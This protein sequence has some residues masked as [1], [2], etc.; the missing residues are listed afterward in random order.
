M[1]RTLIITLALSLMA[2][3]V[4]AQPGSGMGRGYGR[5]LGLGYRTGLQGR[6]GGRG[7]YCYRNSGF[8]GYGLNS[9]PGL[10]EKQLQKI[11][12]IH[13]KELTENQELYNTLDTKELTLMQISR[14]GDNTAE[15]NKLI[16]EIGS[17]RVTLQKSRVNYQQKIRN[18][19]T[20]EQQAYFDTWCGSRGGPGAG[21]GRGMRG[22]GFGRGRG[23]RGR[24]GFGGRGVW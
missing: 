18:V 20:K 14:K 2:G 12:D 24:G 9:I 17:L 3:I 10:T 16:E 5:G 19:L 11:D 13:L 22:G 7:I 1:K 8:A 21:R 23:G 4:S 6:M 15:I